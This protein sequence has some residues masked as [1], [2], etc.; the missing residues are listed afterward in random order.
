MLTIDQSFIREKPTLI[1]SMPY[2]PE[3]KAFYDVAWAAGSSGAKF[4]HEGKDWFVTRIDIDE[5]NDTCQIHAIP[6]RPDI[7]GMA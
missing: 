2:S 1:A 6:F 5:T 7:L 4:T 3:N